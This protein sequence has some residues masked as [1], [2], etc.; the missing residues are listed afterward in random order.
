MTYTLYNMDM[1]DLANNPAFADCADLVFADPPYN[2]GQ[3]YGKTYNDKRSASTYRLWLDQVLES[4]S[5]I[6]SPNAS[7]WIMI[8]EKHTDY[9]GERIRARELTRRRIVVWHE[10]FGAYRTDNL[11]NS[12]RFL[13]Y[14]VMNPKKFT[15]NADAIRIVSDRLVRGDARANPRGRIPPN[16]WTD[17]RVCGTFKERVGR[18]TGAVPPNQLPESLVS[19]IVSLCSNEGDLVFDPFSGSGTT[20]KICRDLNRNFIGCEIN[21]VYAITAAERMKAELL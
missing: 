4:I 2:I 1:R 17:S 20:G 16:L 11:S 8:G 14:Y 19:R 13:H 15:F 3:D 12:C 10:G 9:L 21:P 18:N 6:A 7:I 5:W